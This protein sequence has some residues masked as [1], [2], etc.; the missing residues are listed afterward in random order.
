[1][2]ADSI[3]RPLP[4]QARAQLELAEAAAEGGGGGGAGGGG[5]DLDSLRAA[6]AAAPKGEAGAEPRFA[7]AQ[8]LT[9]R[10]EAAEAIELLLAILRDDHGWAEGKA[11]ELLFK[12]FD[13]LGA[14]HELTK[15]GR[16]RLA[17]LLFN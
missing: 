15:R 12:T 2:H 10:G 5:A 13:S 8:A 3:E 17:N 4:R 1:M 11:K 6:A 9:A 7:L 16:R 14:G